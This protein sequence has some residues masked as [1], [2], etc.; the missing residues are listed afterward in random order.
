MQRL[1]V[2]VPLL[3]FASAF[4]QGMPP[5]TRTVYKC[6][7]GGKVHYSDSP[8]LGAKKLA[9]EP[10]RGLNK[11][12][13]QE[14]QGTDVRNERFREGLAEA[15]KP[16]TGMDAKQIDQFGRRQRLSPEAQRQ[17]RVL[18]QQLP[19][20]EA[21][22]AATAGASAASRLLTAQQRLLELRAEYRRL[23]CD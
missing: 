3:G 13:G 21:A 22:E 12:T 19:A 1:L 23:R 10:T 6:E 7:E 15:V 2:L 18:D 8:C 16:L 17:C 20:V 14:L 9:V 5:P 11:S 4:A